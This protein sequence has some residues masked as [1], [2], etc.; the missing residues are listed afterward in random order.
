[1]YVLDTDHCIE[2]LRGNP[3]ILSRFRSL[4]RDAVIYTTIITIAELLYGIYRLPN[5]QRKLE[6]V[7]AFRRD[8]EVLGLDLA[9]ARVYGQLKAELVQRG[10]LLADNDLFIASIVLSRGLVLVTH[11]SQHYERISGLRLEDWVA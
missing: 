5:P 8:A 1:M 7:D 11:N 6:D 2:L 10:E 4:R 3:G 9:A